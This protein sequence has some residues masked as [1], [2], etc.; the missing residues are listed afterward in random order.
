MR[1]AL[2]LGCHRSLCLESHSTISRISGVS[3]PIDVNASNGSSTG[4]SS[5]RCP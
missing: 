3:T 2:K 5:P 4:H 1:N